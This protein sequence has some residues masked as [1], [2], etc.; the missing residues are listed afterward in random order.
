[1]DG[2]S[3]R[4]ASTASSASVHDACARLQHSIVGTL[5][6]VSSGP[7][8]TAQRTLAGVHSARWSSRPLGEEG[9]TRRTKRRETKTNAAARSRKPARSRRCTSWTP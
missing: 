2:E 9:G 5:T 1:M 6:C 4:R 3:C 7:S 8:R